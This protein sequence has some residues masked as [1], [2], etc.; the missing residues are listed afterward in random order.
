M[1]VLLV[2]W[3][4]EE[5]GR[6]A[7]PLTESGHEVRILH[8]VEGSTSLRCFDAE[9][10]EVIVISLD[11]LPSQGRAV[12]AAL[13]GRKSMR[14]TAL[15][16]CGGEPDKVD[17]AK[18]DFREAA[19]TTWARLRGALR[20][21]ARRPAS[22]HP[23]RGISTLGP[24]VQRLGI[25]ADSLVVT[26]N[27]PPSFERILGALPEGASIE[28]DG[29]GPADRVILFCRSEAELARDF[30]R[31][32]RRMKNNDG[33]WIAWPKTSSRVPTDLTMN[34]VRVFAMARGFVDYK[35]CSIDATWSASCFARRRTKA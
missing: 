8:Q 20:D 3:N 30:D 35:V 9:P 21:A 18:S 29:A 13:T 28:E 19:F 27:A 7:A 12:A 1:R 15:V 5:A 31:V 2:H 33:L 4:E 26:L 24:L 6:L 25:R 17:R 10:P 14:T 16:F 11:R 23:H 32:A 34:V 22:V